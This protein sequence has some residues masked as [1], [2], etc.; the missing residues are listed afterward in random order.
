MIL[1]TPALAALASFFFSTPGLCVSD[2]NEN[3]KLNPKAV[4]IPTFDFDGLGRLG[5][6]GDFDTIS[7]YQYVGQQ[8][9]LQASSSDIEDPSNNQD[10]FAYSEDLAQYLPLGNV[11]GIVKSTCQLGDR[12]YFAGNFT[13]VSSQSAKAGLAYIDTSTGN[14]TTIPSSSDDLH[15]DTI[16]TLY[17]DSDEKTVWL[18]GNLSYHNKQGVVAWNES[19]QQWSMPSFEGF[20]QNSTVRAISKI[21]DNLVFG[22]QF[23]QIG[24]NATMVSAQTNKSTHENVTLVS[25]EQQVSFKLGQLQAEGTREDSNAAS[26]YC[27]RS[28]GSNW[29]LTDDRAGT[30][31]LALPFTFIPTRLRMYNLKDDENGTKTF[32]FLAFPLN[33][34]MNFTYMDP[35]TH[36][37]EVCNAWCPLPQSKSHDFVDFFFVNPIQM[38]SFQ[39]SVLDYYGAAAGLGGIELFQQN[40]VTYANQSF[41]EPTNCQGGYTAKTVAKT[42]IHGSDWKTLSEPGLFATYLSATIPSASE[43]GDYSVR[44]QPNI[45]L[46]GNYSIQLYTPGCLSD[47]TCAQRGAVKVSVYPSKNA[48]PVETLL[49]QTN[50]FEKFDQVYYGTLKPEGDFQPYLEVKPAPEQQEYPLVFVAEK[51]MYN[52]DFAT[53]KAL[54]ELSKDES[55]EV[56][57]NG[58]FEFSS[59]NFTR[60]QHNSSFSPVGLTAINL[61]GAN[62]SENATITGLYAVDSTRLAIGGDFS[63]DKSKNFFVMK[64]GGDKLELDSFKSPPYTEQITRFVPL[65]GGKGLGAVF[66]DNS[67]MAYYDAGADKWTEIPHGSSSSELILFNETTFALSSKETN[68]LQLY[69]ASSTSLSPLPHLK[70][71]L[72]A[73]YVNQGLQIYFGQAQVYE[74]SAQSAVFM[75]QTL[76]L[77]GLPSG[78]NFVDIAQSTT[79]TNSTLQRRAATSLSPS[80]NGNTINVGLF[81][82]DSTAVLAGSFNATYGQNSSDIISNVAIVTNKTVVG[83]SERLNGEVKSLLLQDDWL[84]IGG[85]FDGNVQDNSVGGIAM[86]HV[87]NSTF[88][89]IQPPMVSGNLRSVDSLQYVSDSKQL[90]VMGSFAEAGSLGCNGMCLYDLQQ[91]RWLAPASGLS[92]SVTA[93]QF[94]ASNTLFFSGNLTMNSTQAYFA[95]YDF[96]MSQFSYDLKLSNG[97]PGPVNSFVLNGEGTESIF[98]S[99][100]N[101]KTGEVYLGYWNNSAWQLLDAPFEQGAVVEQVSMLRLESQHKSN[102][103]L[104]GEEVLMVSGNMTLRGFGSASVVL[105]DGENWQPLFVSTTSSGR[106]G[107]VK[108]FYSQSSQHFNSLI[109]KHYMKR[110][111]VVLVSLAIAVGLVM[112]LVLLGLVLAAVRRRKQGYRPANNRVS[113][114]DMTETVPPAGLLQQMDTIKG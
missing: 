15:V 84:F 21:G 62:I 20:G 39:V 96:E 108:Q 3:S 105:Y 113:E 71:G 91:S 44:M 6:V 46:T 29:E 106:P 50:E 18:G 63:V 114:T 12:V 53:I 43:L 28:S 8:S 95:Q 65:S 110:G 9:L 94:I 78:F 79:T 24:A 77:S 54:Q 51:A 76:Q 89:A 72:S 1:R 98:A 93:S 104:P 56:S 88:A 7:K 33:G 59:S 67:G 103:I 41:N 16:E 87:N 52:M 57:L 97:L 22:G 5:F 31:Q 10:I 58:L 2:V 45:S 109:G 17:C 99:G 61:A 36:K 74:N 69:N 47:G 37:V 49:Y 25:L 55:H 13:Q 90:V 82:N 60:W 30:W 66:G 38:D 112:L 80:R 23:W 85:D 107:S 92:G 42:S 4:K 48:D 35:D 86:Y 32:R 101:N 81:L 26:I 111:F 83:L 11:N 27:P 100:S 70:G 64:A 34:I 40:L 14:I 68:N 73:S 102:S 19:S 75:G